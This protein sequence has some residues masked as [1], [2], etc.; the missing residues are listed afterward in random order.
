MQVD[1]LN[2]DVDG[3]LITSLRCLHES[4]SKKQAIACMKETLLLFKDRLDACQQLSG[5]QMEILSELLFIPDSIH[6]HQSYLSFISTL[7]AEVR[8]AVEKSLAARISVSQDATQY[9]H[10]LTA[11]QSL[12]KPSVFEGLIRNRAMDII[13]IIVAVLESIHQ[14]K[15]LKDTE[16]AHKR[17]TMA[18]TIGYIIVSTYSD[19]LREIEE[20]EEVLQT[21]SH[22]AGVV[23][24]V[25]LNLQLGGCCCDEHSSTM[26]YYI[27]TSFFLQNREFVNVEITM[28]LLIYSIMVALE[29]NPKDAS[30]IVLLC[31]LGED[32]SLVQLKRNLFSTVYGSNETSL[33]TSQNALN[34]QKFTSDLSDR[35]R[36]LFLKA[37]SHSLLD[38]LS[39]ENGILLVVFNKIFGSVSETYQVDPWSKIYYMDSVTSLLKGLCRKRVNSSGDDALFGQMTTE[40]EEHALSIAFDNLDHEEVIVIRSAQTLLQEVLNVDKIRSSCHSGSTVA[41]NQ[42]LQY[43]SRLGTL[44]VHQCDVILHAAQRR[45]LVSLKIHM[46]SLNIGYCIA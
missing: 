5:N 42:V 20:F 15:G 37:I 29:S 16:E 2:L 11:V 10:I 46:T 39:C 44:F 30:V 45:F 22:V 26:V 13:H 4:R 3:D 36:L 41:M 32:S 34:F 7:P 19:T 17:C 8:L 33:M 21:C 31:I 24:K 6:L 1:A 9:P 18:A 28:S 43:C 25:R 23:M 35:Q 27:P 38:A 12:M 40:L 14:C